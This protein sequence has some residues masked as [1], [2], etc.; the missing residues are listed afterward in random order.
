MCPLD[1]PA[2]PPPPPPPSFLNFAPFSSYHT[3][4]NG[5]PGWV[6]QWLEGSLVDLPI[7]P[8]PRSQRSGARP[9]EQRGPWRLQSSFLSGDCQ[10]WVEEKRRGYWVRI[11]DDPFVCL[12]VKDFE[13]IKAHVTLP[14][15]CSLCGLQ[16]AGGETKSR[17]DFGN[18]RSFQ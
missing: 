7:S 11:I 15:A 16:C 2:L 8:G 12:A 4:A 6:S 14:K 9:V 10:R 3:L 5:P 13:S 1:P 18:Y 17:E